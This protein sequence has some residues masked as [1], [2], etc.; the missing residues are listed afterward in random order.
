MDSH[1][2]KNMVILKDIPSNIVEEA[3]IVLKD[4]VKI[5]KIEKEMVEKIKGYNNEKTEEKIKSKDYMVK[6]A[7]MV[8]KDYISK[9]E[10][11][12]YE[13]INGNKKLNVKYKRLKA[14]T[15]FLTCFSMLSIWLAF[16]K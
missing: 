14:L 2:L 7:E 12:E 6:E 9:I 8:V 15:I 3:F 10:R 4:N 5:H 11:K 16:L 1:S 13:L